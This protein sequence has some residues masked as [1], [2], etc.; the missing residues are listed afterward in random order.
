M[1]KNYLLIAFRK[2]WKN[3]GLSFINIFGLATG[4]A[5][6]LMIFLFVQDE[7]KYDRH[8]ADAD[9]VYRV[10]KDFINDDGSRIPDATTPGPLAGAMQEEMPEV[11]SVTRLHPDWGGTNILEYGDK[12]FT[13]SKVWRVDSSFLDIFSITF[14]KGHAKTALNDLT[15]VVL[16]ETTAHRYFGNEDPIG[17]VMKM[18]GRED[19]TVTGVIRDV[20]PQSHI[21]YNFLMSY[22]R[23]PQNA[24]TNWGSY[25][26]YTYV[27]VKPG[28]NIKAFEKKIQD[29]H[30][31][32]SSEHFSQF[33]TQPLLDIHLTSHLKWELEPNGDKLYVYIFSVIGIFILVIAAINYIN[34]STARSSLR[35]KETGIRKVS[36]AHRTSLVFQF[37]M[38]SVILCSISALLALAIAWLVTPVVNELTQKQLQ[39]ISNPIVLMY[40]FGVTILIGMI[41]GLLPALY[42]SSFRPVAAL[43][44]LRLTEGGALTLRK[45][46]VV[47]QFTISIALIIS[48]L[49][50]VQQIDYLQTARLGFDKD[51]VVVLRNARGLSRADQSSF[52]NSVKQLSGVQ[53]AATAGGILGQG[54]STSRLRAVG[55]EQE[56]QL[57]FGSVGFGYMDVTGIEMAEGHGFTNE[58]PADT[59]NNG[60]LGGPMH[61]RLGGIVI[62]ERAVKEFGLGSPAVGKRL[63]WATDGDT[64]YYVEVVGVA[65]DFHFTSLR[66]E[67]KPFGF[68]MNPGRQSN[69]TIRLSKGD[70]PSTIAQLEEL[71]K[72]SFP[73]RTFE[74]TFLSESFAKMY[75]AEGRFQ[76]VFISLVVLGIIIACLGLFALASFSAEQRI[77]E[78]GI[79]KVL[80][81]S[82]LH[83]M[84]LLSKDFLRL[85]AISIVLAIPV[86]AYAMK[87]WL[88]GFAYHVSMEWWIFVVSAVIALVIAMLTI[89]TQAFKAAVVNPTKSL[90][91]E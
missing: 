5:C 29:V 1:F 52:L 65:K 35:A 40:L 25:N 27:K 49:I 45:S 39:I 87:G 24:H 70:I 81:A 57:N 62:N 30:D 83:V 90:R 86:A 31:R 82:V 3:K 78:I 32:N 85:V 21:H 7:L 16:T 91:S 28:T 15:S 46:L 54:F 51:Q 74:Y 64:L 61:Q 58:F 22:R 34:L 67:I 72:R 26:Y 80:G 56:Q 53:D 50:I 77:K 88:Q 75:I 13:E 8:H 44:G 9:R 59:M 37:L 63:E 76:K 89:S 11:E 84:T 23:L 20:P 48:T 79:R 66:N 17:K 38:E 69:F 68:I 10:V 73:E 43:K 4:M 12:K 36:G 14:V 18:D 6:T 41:A 33:Y 2:L 47:V 60:I 42:L 71:W 55:S 19:I